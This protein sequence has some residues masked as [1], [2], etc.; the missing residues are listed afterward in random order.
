MPSLA[1]VPRLT[2]QSRQ[3]AIVGVG[4]AALTAL[5]QIRFAIPWS[6]VPITGQT[7]GVTLISL[8]VGRRLGLSAV[9][10]YVLLGFCGLPVFAGPSAAFAIGPTSGYLLGMIFSAALIGSLVDFGWT[11]SFRSTLVV[12]GLGSACVLT[13]GALVLSISVPG[14]NAFLIGVLPFIPGDILK[15]TSASVVASVANRAVAK[16]QN[17]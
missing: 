6:P 10:A 3:I 14:Q 8:L 2:N 4:I 15:T 7:F 1:A 16:R 12:A 17:R 13:T 9:A 11:S 5:A